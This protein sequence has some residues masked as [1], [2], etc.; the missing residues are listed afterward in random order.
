MTTM[1]KLLCIM[2]FTLLT[3]N[4]YAAKIGPC[5]EDE[6]VEYFKE[7][8]KY[9]KAGY[10]E[11]M[12]TLA[13]MYY[14]GHGTDASLS[15]ALKHYRSAAKYGS[16]K[17]QYKTAMIYLTN[18]EY[19][20]L[21]K[22]VKYLKKAARSKNVDA[23]F[24]LGVIYYKPDFYERDLEEADK[25][26]AKAYVWRHKKI[27]AFIEF[28]KKSNDFSPANFPDLSDEIADNPIPVEIAK[29]QTA[30]I[31][32]NKAEPNASETVKAEQLTAKTEVIY[33]EQSDIEVITVTSNLHDLFRSQL[34][35][36]RNTYPEKGA[37]STGTKIIG[38]TCAQT[39]SC[40]VVEI[41]DYN[42]LV[43]NLMG[44]HAVAM[45]YP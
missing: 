3:M 36:L 17:G 41:G 24:L 14:Y 34:A 31:E 32:E 13:E 16:V 8:K 35:S 25:W 22:G 37:V 33:P 44:N 39:M 1:S 2:C 21:D 5:Q 12:A 11:A 18:E 29:V 28:V 42:R 38:K 19:K 40:G 23:A 26:L 7:Y 4:S 9:A 10:A 6:C 15:K 43:N 27:N 30:A 45:F 20:D